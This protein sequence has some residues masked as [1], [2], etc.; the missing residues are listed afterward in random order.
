MEIMNIKNILIVLFVCIFYFSCKKE[1]SNNKVNKNE[2]KELV[3]TRAPVSTPVSALE[4]N[5]L[6]YK[7]ILP[8]TLQVNKS[9]TAIIEFE[10]DFDKIVDPIQYAV[11]LD[12]TK[13]RLVQFFY[14][15][16]KLPLNNNQEDRKIE[17]VY[18]SNKKFKVENIVFRDKGDHMF[19]G[20]I[21]DEIRYISY[22]NKGKRDSIHFDQRRQ[23]IKKKVVVV[24]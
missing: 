17:P 19:E 12:S 15:P 9:Y 24:D 13:D 3:I 8:E 22:D 18:V 10:S 5:E 14:A 1:D 6:K 20:Y 7:L 23:M 16:Y 21:F 4:A 2:E 11:E